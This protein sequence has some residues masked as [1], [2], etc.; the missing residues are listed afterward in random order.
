MAYFLH[1]YLF[2]LS[3]L[4]SCSGNGKSAA[5]NKRPEVQNDSILQL[6]GFESFK[7]TKIVIEQSDTIPDYWGGYSEDTTAIDYEKITILIDSANDVKLH[8]YKL[9]P[10]DYEKYHSEYLTVGKQI[11]NIDSLLHGEFQDYL[12]FTNI[13]K[14]KWRDCDFILLTAYNRVNLMNAE[15]FSCLLIQMQ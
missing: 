12:D 5:I 10:P 3:I 9:I 6:K 14:F 2:L 7:F 1:H 13:Y 11:L 8:A 15:F 4:I